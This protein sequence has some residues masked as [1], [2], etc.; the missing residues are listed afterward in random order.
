MSFKVSK[1]SY[2]DQLQQIAELTNEN[3]P[4]N[5]LEKMCAIRS[6]CFCFCFSLVQKV[7]RYFF[8]GQ[9]IVTNSDQSLQ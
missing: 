5:S 7:S 8:F 3:S 2:S 6:D 9:S 1:N 4:L